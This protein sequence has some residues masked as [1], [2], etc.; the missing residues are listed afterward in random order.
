MRRPRHQRPFQ[1]SVFCLI[2][3]YPL[4]ML[5]IF[6]GF[7]LKKAGPKKTS[8]LQSPAQ[9]LPRLCDVQKRARRSAT[10]LPLCFPHEIQHGEETSTFITRTT[11]S[12]IAAVSNVP[13]CSRKVWY[14][15]LA[16]S[17]SQREHFT[18]SARKIFHLIKLWNMCVLS[19][20]SASGQGPY[21]H[22]YQKNHR[23]VVSAVF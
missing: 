20:Y 6:R 23:C 18:F 9:K 10:L 15:S 4:K 3:F 8:G 2:E 22:S 14:I 11:R 7:F 17:R 16:P 13:T 5:C 12:D 19:K 1:N 21:E